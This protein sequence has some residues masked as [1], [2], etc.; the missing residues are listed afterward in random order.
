MVYQWAQKLEEESSREVVGR[1]CSNA[2]CGS[3]SVKRETRR[4]RWQSE[5]R[6]RGGGVFSLVAGSLRGR[7]IEGRGRKRKEK[8]GARIKRT[9]EE[10]LQ[11]PCGIGWDQTSRPFAQEAR[12]GFKPSLNLSL[13]NDYTACGIRLCRTAS[14]LSLLAFNQNNKKIY[15]IISLTWVQILVDRIF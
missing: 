9:E 1:R 6:K 7:E 3:E 11:V 2:V 8:K 14:N 10:A 12:N 5:L 15:N 13:Q 4:G